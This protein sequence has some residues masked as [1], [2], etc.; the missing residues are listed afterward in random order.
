M[1]EE[2]NQMLLIIVRAEVVKLVII[3]ALINTIV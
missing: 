2:W 1:W 3:K